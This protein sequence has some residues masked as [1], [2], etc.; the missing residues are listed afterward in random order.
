MAKIA[1]SGNALMAVLCL[2]GCCEGH[3]RCR[4]CIVELDHG[5]YDRDR[6][7]EH[8][9]RRCTSLMRHFVDLTFAPSLLPGSVPPGSTTGALIPGAGTSVR[10]APGHRRAL[11]DTI[12]IAAIAAAADAHRHA[13]AP[14]AIQPVALFPHLHRTPPQDWTAPCFAGIN[15]VR[16]V[17]PT[18]ISPLEAREFLTGFPGLRCF[19]VACSLSGNGSARLEREIQQKNTEIGAS[20]ADGGRLRLVYAVDER[21]EAKD[22]HQ[23][24]TG[25]PVVKP[26]LSPELRGFGSPSTIDRASSS[27]FAWTCRYYD[28]R[29]CIPAQGRDRETITLARP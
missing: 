13:A 16:K 27:M 24:P 17:A 11:A 28:H 12:N 22:D 9:S 19:G 21:Q 25:P 20:A 18:G 15:T 23:S 26:R 6:H 1:P 5:R 8:R 29:A 10:R 2:E 14:A 4:R 3:I 7:R